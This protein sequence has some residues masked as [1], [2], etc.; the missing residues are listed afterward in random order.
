MLLVWDILQQ[1]QS[2]IWRVASSQIPV[3]QMEHFTLTFPR[4][5]V[6]NVAAHLEYHC[7]AAFLVAP[8]HPGCCNQQKCARFMCLHVVVRANPHVLA[9]VLWNQRG[10]NMSQDLLTLLNSYNSSR[11]N[12]EV[13]VELVQWRAG[14]TVK[15][16]AHPITICP[17]CS[18]LSAYAV[19]QEGCFTDG[20]SLEPDAR[21]NQRAPE[22]T[23]NCCGAS[24]LGAH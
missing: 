12:W 24:K 22:Q 8:V 9:L 4:M 5:S 23:G 7:N 14:F 17:M 15:N 10:S 19:T 18:D 3:R 13:F 1:P 6:F 16:K 11:T 2:V 21:T 20:W